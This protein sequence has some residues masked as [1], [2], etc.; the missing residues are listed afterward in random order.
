MLEFSCCKVTLLIEGMFLCNHKSSTHTHTHPT[1]H[2]EGSGYLAQKGNCEVQKS[3]ETITAG[4]K[5]Y[6]Y[7]LEAALRL[8]FYFALQF[9]LPDSLLKKKSWLITLYWESG[10]FFFTWTRRNRKTVKI[11]RTNRLCFAYCSTNY[12]LNAR[13]IQQSPSAS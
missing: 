3:C 11:F 6:T 8:Q 13:C 7:I 12:T 4:C 2:R 10:I 5:M 9:W 1:F